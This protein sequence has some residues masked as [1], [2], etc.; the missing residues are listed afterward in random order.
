MQYT[1]NKDLLELL[2]EY[3]KTKSRKL[4]NELGKAFLEIAKRHLYR[5]QFVNYSKDIKEDAVSD[6]VYYMVKYMDRFD[7][8]RSLYPNPFAYFTTIANMAMVQNI[9]KFHKKEET[10]LSLDFIDNFNENGVGTDVADYKINM[11]YF[12]DLSRLNEGL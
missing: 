10:T 12:N 4:Y 6:A 3:R 1:K 5:P 7:E 2:L 9:N 8:N 11:D